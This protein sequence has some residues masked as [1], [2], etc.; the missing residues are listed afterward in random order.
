MET[1]KYN[2]KTFKIVNTYK[3]S[4]EVGA[5]EGHGDYRKGKIYYAQEIINNDDVFDYFAAM[6]FPSCDARAWLRALRREWDALMEPRPTLQDYMRAHIGK[7]HYL[8]LDIHFDSHWNV[9]LKNGNGTHTL[10]TL[11]SRPDMPL[12]WCEWDGTRYALIEEITPEEACRLV[13]TGEMSPLAPSNVVCK[14]DVEDE[15][16]AIQ[17]HFFA[18]NDPF[19]IGGTYLV[20]GLTQCMKSAQSLA[21]LA[22][23]YVENNLVPV[24]IVRNLKFDVEQMMDTVQSFNARMP[25]LA[26]KT[27][28]NPD[29]L[30]HHMEKKVDGIPLLISLYNRVNLDRLDESLISKDIRIH[31]LIDEAD[32]T[33]QSEKGTTVTEKS[34]NSSIFTSAAMVTWVTATPCALFC[35]PAHMKRNT[36]LFKAYQIDIVPQYNRYS[37]SCALHEPRR[38]INFSS[39]SRVEEMVGDFLHHTR[40]RRCLVTASWTTRLTDQIKVADNISTMYKR[41]EKTVVTIAWAADKISMFFEG[42]DATSYFQQFRVVMP[43]SKIL[44]EGRLALTISTNLRE[45]YDALFEVETAIYD[46]LP[47]TDLQGPDIIVV[48]GQL[49]DRGVRFETSSHRWILTDMFVDVTTW[50]LESIVQVVGRLCGVSKDTTTK[51]LWTS[52]TGKVMVALKTVRTFA[53]KLLLHGYQ[54]FRDYNQDHMDIVRGSITEPESIPDETLPMAQMMLSNYTASRPGPSAAVTRVNKRVRG[55]VEPTMK[56]HKISRTAFQIPVPECEMHRS[57]A[58]AA[59]GQMPDGSSIPS[60]RMSPDEQMASLWRMPTMEQAFRDI[61]ADTE[62]GS[63]STKDLNARL[64][65]TKTIKNKCQATKFLSYG[66]NHPDVVGWMGPGGAAKNTKGAWVTFSGRGGWRFAE[67]QVIEMPLPPMA[68]ASAGGGVGG[69]ANVDTWSEIKRMFAVGETF[70]YSDLKNLQVGDKINKG[71][72]HIV[73]QLVKNKM[74]EKVATATYKRVQ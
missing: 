61:A 11:D 59:K 8:L 56:R 32:G 10:V 15:T 72:G 27:Y 3:N 45:A 34:L 9:L 24:I 53:E 69:N 22:L 23:T 38:I 49:A 60:I 33:A 17:Q 42:K 44:T 50:S 62:N 65:E 57:T 74:L 29:D 66:R 35:N 39:V 52:D 16:C 1:I 19:Q 41:S 12:R 26:F 64:V 6:D 68:A 5:P 70:T 43:A 73:H 63:I 47:I 30:I 21:T 14:C 25:Y 40:V 71:H 18:K 46:G 13:R 36:A 31:L 48:A 2:N 55:D 7:D 4:Y 67:D 37:A 28:Q 58:P 20:Y 54:S 51:T